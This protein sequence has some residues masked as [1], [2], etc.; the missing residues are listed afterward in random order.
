M[1]LPIWSACEFSLADHFLKHNNEAMNKHFR[2]V[3]SVLKTKAKALGFSRSELKGV[4]ASIADNLDLKDDASD[5]EI[6]SAIDD[7]VEDAMPFLKISQSAA[8]RAIQNFKDAHNVK[9][10]DDDDDDGGKEPTS[11]QSTSPST[12][13]KSDETLDENNPL[14][15]LLKS[16]SDKQDA[17]AN[18]LNSL[19]ASRLTVNRKSK[20]EE[21]VKNTGTFGKRILREFDRMSFKDDDDFEDYLD[22]IKTDIEDEN[23]ER[24]EK[25]L[26]ALGNPPA[27]GGRQVTHKETKVMSDDEVKKLAH[28]DAS[29]TL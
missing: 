15:K 26:E 27:A 7:A 28:G 8:Q 16:M 6:G 24:A 1:V 17:M 4:A 11:S 10:D 12:N 3:L 23:Q 13:S 18:E 21:L 14:Y 9:D 22:G 2:K 5:E 20:V 19:K 29:L 25:G